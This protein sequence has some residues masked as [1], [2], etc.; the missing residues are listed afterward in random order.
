MNARA[1]SRSALLGL[2]G[3]LLAGGCGAA[4]PRQPVTV[5]AAASLTDVMEALAAAF[6]QEHP[7][8]EVALNLAGSSLLAR[9]ILQ[10]APADV[11]FSANVAW[12][13]AVAQ[14]GRVAE[15]PPV[16]IRN[17][18]VVAGLADAAPLGSLA[19]LADV[20]RI[21][22]ADPTHVPAGQYARDGLQCA[23]LW[24]AVEAR[25]VPTLD[26][27]AAL[28]AVQVGAAAV[29]IVYASDLHGRAEGRAGVRELLAWPPSCAP[30]VRYAAALVKGAAAAEGGTAFLRFAL[31]PA[32]AALWQQFGF[33]VAFAPEVR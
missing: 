6:E 11:F 2:A 26:V 20:P 30:D 24:G 19:D 23:G 18:L 17:R 3:L 25:I 29:A 9:Q 13:E 5:Y 32:Q 15:A 12:M 7:R 14:G 21:A 28:H 1:P 4:P 10:G 33:E 31:D 27:R 22:L 8:Y 16:P